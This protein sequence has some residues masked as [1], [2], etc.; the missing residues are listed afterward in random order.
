MIGIGLFGP[1]FEIARAF[2][3]APFAISDCSFMQAWYDRDRSTMLFGYIARVDRAPR[4]LLDMDRAAHV[5]FAPRACW[6]DHPMPA[7]IHIVP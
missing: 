5:A 1:G 6:P 4:W 2:M 7:A 3:R